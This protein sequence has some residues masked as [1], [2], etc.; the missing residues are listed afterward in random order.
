MKADPVIVPRGVYIGE[1][2]KMTDRDTVEVTVPLA[3][4]RQ[5]TT[6]EMHRVG[7]IEETVQ[8]RSGTIGQKLIR[9]PA[10]LKQ[11]DVIVV[12][13]SRQTDSWEGLIQGS[14][15]GVEGYEPPPLSSSGSRNY[16]KRG[17]GRQCMSPVV[18]YHKCTRRNTCLFI[19]KRQLLKKILHNRGTAALPFESATAPRYNTHLTWRLSTSNRYIDLEETRQDYAFAFWDM[20]VQKGFQL[21]LTWIC[22]FCG[23]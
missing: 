4:R 13:I 22:Y 18:I 12:I 21:F 16:W 1:T 2:A 19:R 15:D 6:A 17:G 20:R 7:A 11:T 14:G 3:N 8:R 9:N 5:R 10:P 23:L